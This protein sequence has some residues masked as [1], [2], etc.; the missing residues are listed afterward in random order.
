LTGIFLSISS[1]SISFSIVLKEMASLGE[2]T[3]AGYRVQGVK[4][5][6]IMAA[7]DLERNISESITFYIL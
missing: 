4:V 5:T 6:S 1:W 3:C 2:E 7:K